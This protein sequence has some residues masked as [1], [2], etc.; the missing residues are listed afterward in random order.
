[1]EPKDSQPNTGV[2]RP[3]RR[4][5][6]KVAKDDTLE[7]AKMDCGGFESVQFAPPEHAQRL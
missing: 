7:L 1:M 4:I 6:A 5:R 2:G 3:P